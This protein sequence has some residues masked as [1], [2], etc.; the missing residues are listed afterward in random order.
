MTQLTPSEAQLR[1]RRR[2]GQTRRNSVDLLPGLLLAILIAVLATF[3][4]HVL[5]VVGGPVIAVVS[6]AL[7]SLRY[8]GRAALMPGIRFG[9][10]YVLQLSVVLLGLGLSLQE[11]SQVG[12][13]SLPVLI[14]S[15]AAA[16]I[17]G[18]T[19][20]K[21]LGLDKDLRLLVSVGTG[22]CGASAIAATTAT[23][24]AAEVDVSY[25][26]ATIFTFNVAAV[27]T[28]PT[29]GHILG[30]SPHGFGLFA[31]TAVNDLSSVVAAANIFSTA[32]VGYAVIVKLTR[33]LMIVPI[34]LATSLSRSRDQA[35]GI[36][37]ETKVWAL[38]RRGVPPFLLLFI[39]AVV[40]NSTVGVPELVRAHLSS[41]S[42]F[43][44]TVALASIGLSTNI[45]AIRSTG[46]KPLLLGA[47]LWVTVAVTS[48]GLQ[49]LI[50]V[51]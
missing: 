18:L 42:S 25:A 26:I 17:V 11:V 36:K 7:L 35:D 19:I 8:H 30:M 6:G 23:I 9:A 31:G 5:P 37:E 47:I 10:K 1:K 49:R 13:S 32:S 34:T 3:A 2:P 45:S 51:H 27:L 44:I 39:G 46:A 28:F 48:L 12:T 50:G 22:I 43:L 20:G 38:I 29:L 40:L 41:T 4:G 16:L 15:L 24:G 33:T 14:G 21:L